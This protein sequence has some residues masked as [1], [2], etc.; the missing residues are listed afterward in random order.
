MPEENVVKVK[1]VINE[2]QVQELKECSN[3]RW[4]SRARPLPATI[5]LWG[6]EMFAFGECRGSP[7][8]ALA[9]DRKLVAQNDPNGETFVLVKQARFPHTYHDDW[10][11]VWEVR[12]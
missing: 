8:S 6:M 12:T 3:C 9:G 1:D 7:P 10:C 2:D 5:E 11:R 4:W